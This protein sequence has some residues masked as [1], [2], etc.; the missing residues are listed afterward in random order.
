[1]VGILVVLIGVAVF[2]W[3]NSEGTEVDPTFAAATQQYLCPHCNGTFEVTG[4]ESQEMINSR[5]GIVCKLCD[6]LIEDHPTARVETNVAA[7]SDDEEDT[8]VDVPLE[9]TGVRRRFGG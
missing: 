3:V 8:S 5:G 7:S 9:S 1:M 2:V 4:G 6:K